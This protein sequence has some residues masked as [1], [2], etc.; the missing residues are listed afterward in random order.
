M[1]YNT[2][3]GTNEKASVIALGTA[4]YGS[5]IPEKESFLILDTYLEMGGNF[6][7][8]AHSYMRWGGR[9]DAKS[10]LTIGKWLRNQ[11]RKE[12]L[13]GTKGADMGMDEKTI[14]KQI[15]ESLERLGTDFIDFYWLH[16]D[17]A[18][19]PAGEI[20]EWL[21]RW[22]DD[23]LIHAFGCSNWPVARMREAAEYAER[24]AIRGFGASQIGWSLARMLPEVLS[25]GGQIFMDEGTFSYHQQTSF[26]VVA[27]SSQAGGFFAGKYD[28]ETPTPGTEPNPNIVRCFGSD[29]NYARLA[30]VKEMAK[31]KGCTPNQLALA[32]LTNQA[33]PV[34]PIAG[35]NSVDQVRDSCRAGDIVLSD[36]ELSRLSEAGR[37][38]SQ[39]LAAESQDES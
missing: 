24:H 31:E 7:D 11:N 4:W 37:L 3:P 39:T 9:G 20:L 27:Y 8:T 18:S 26:P 17:D 21:N 29:E 19:V 1:R 33:F 30:A 5:D 12:I 2:L 6:L 28:P 38:L 35:P 15:L 34:F 32:Y 16:S 25:G 10:E 14:G 22:A 13:I 23:G 36:D